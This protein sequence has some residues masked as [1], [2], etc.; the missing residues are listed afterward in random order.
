MGV[1][2]GDKRFLVQSP[3]SKLLTTPK[4]LKCFTVDSFFGV[5]CSFTDVVPTDSRTGGMRIMTAC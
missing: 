2:V 3:W 5:D 1:H 4:P